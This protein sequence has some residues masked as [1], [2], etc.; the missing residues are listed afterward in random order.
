M[1]LHSVKVDSMQS[2]PPSF[3]ELLVK[4]AQVQDRFVFKRIYD[5]FAPRVNQY[6]I[7]LGCLPQISEEL[8]QEAMMRVYQRAHQFDASKAQAS[9]WI[10][11]IARNLMIDHLR[12]DKITPRQEEYSASEIELEYENQ[13]V[14]DGKK[15]QELMQSL[16]NDQTQ[17]VHLTYFLGL[18]HSQIAQKLSMPIGTVKSNLRLAVKRLRSALEVEQ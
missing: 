6:L 5:H 13:P 18:S 12:K 15:I 11:R 16:P 7:G 17:V 2:E 3:N 1:H 10:F 8:M 4:L 9:T 14:L